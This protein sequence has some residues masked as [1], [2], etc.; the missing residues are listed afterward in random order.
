M[1]VIIWGVRR[2]CF[3]FPYLTLEHNRQVDSPDLFGRQSISAEY[4]VNIIHANE[5]GTGN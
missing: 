5:S 4:Q 2:F 3:V 1:A